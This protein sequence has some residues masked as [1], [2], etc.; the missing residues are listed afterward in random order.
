V[1]APVVG[2]DAGLFDFGLGFE[3]LSTR[4]VASTSSALN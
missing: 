2:F 1:N 3:T 4:E